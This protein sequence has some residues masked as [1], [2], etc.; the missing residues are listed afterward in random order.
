[1]KETFESY[2]ERLKARRTED[3]YNYTDEDLEKYK[4]YIRDCWLNNLSVY[5]CLEFMYFETQS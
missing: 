4:D 1:M 3:S 2:L 5:K